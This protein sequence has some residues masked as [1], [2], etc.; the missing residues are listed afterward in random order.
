MLLAELCLCLCGKTEDICNSTMY[1]ILYGNMIN[2]PTVFQYLWIMKQFQKLSWKEDCSYI[3]VITEQV[4]TCRGRGKPAW[5]TNISLNT[6]S[7]TMLQYRIWS[8]NLRTFFS[9]FGRWKIRVRKICGFFLWRSW[10]GFYSSIIENMVLLLIF[11]CNFV[12]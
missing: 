9:Y 10:S 12:T 11:Y 8:R 5:H 7:V 1:I 4:Y 2:A 6:F 3:F